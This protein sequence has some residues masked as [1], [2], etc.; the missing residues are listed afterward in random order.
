MPSKGG[1]CR[2]ASLA[3]LLCAGGGSAAAAAGDGRWGR[4]PVRAAGRM[5]AAPLFHGLK[6]QAA[7]KSVIPHYC[8]LAVRGGLPSRGR[9]PPSGGSCSGKRLQTRVSWT[10]GVGSVSSSLFEGGPR[11]KYGKSRRVH[12]GRLI[13]VLWPGLGG[14]GQ[15]AAGPGHGLQLPN[16][17]PFLSRRP[18]ELLFLREQGQC[19]FGGPVGPYCL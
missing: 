19:Q 13:Q 7:V 10:A 14:R 15:P 18:V 1:R 3:R 17:W 8:F 9:R 11:G 2:R 6:N 16:A 12:A 5:W 4:P